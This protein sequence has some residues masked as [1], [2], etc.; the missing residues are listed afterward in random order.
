MATKTTIYVYSHGITVKPGDRQVQSSLLNYCKG[1]AQWEYVKKPPTWRTL[2][3]MSRIFAGA[4]ASRDEFR[5]HRTQLDE[6]ITHLGGSGISRNS[7]NLV[8]VPL[9]DAAIVDLTMHDAH[10]P[11]DNQVDLI[12][13][14]ANPN[15]AIKVTELQTGKG[16]MQPLYSRI[17]VPGGWSTMGEMS[18]G[19]EVIAADGTTAKVT[20]VFPH[21]RKQIYRIT[22][23]DNRHTDAGA[24]HLWKIYYANMLS[25]NKW[26]IVTTI[27][28]L[29]I[30]SIPDSDIYIPL[31]DSEVCEDAE[32]AISAYKVGVCL[33]KQKLTTIPNQYLN[34]STSQRFDV[35][36][37]FLD[38]YRDSQYFNSEDLATASTSVQSIAMDI[39]QL[40]RS[41]GG[42]ASTKYSIDN[43]RYA[44][45]IK[46]KDDFEDLKLKVTRVE[47][48]SHQQ[49]QCIS[50]DHPDHLYVTDDFIVTHNTFC[51]LTASSRMSMR[52]V[53]QVRGGYV[54]RWLDDLNAFFE[55]EHGELLV[56]RGKKALVSI[57]NMAKADELDVKFIIITSKTL[58]SYFKA[59]E[60]NP[61]AAVEEYGCRPEQLYTVL[62]VGT[63][64]VDEV[65]EDYHLNY[66]SDIYCNISNV[67][68]LSATLTTEDAF[69]RQMYDVALPMEHWHK[70][71]DYHAYI[72]VNA[73][74]F[75]MH[76][77]SVVN[78][79]ERG[80]DTYSHGAY[81]L[82][83]LRNKEMLSNYLEMIRMVVQRD[84]IE[85]EFHHGQK[86]IIFCRLVEMCEIVAEHIQECLPDLL[87]GV[88]VSGSEDSILKKSDI[89]VSTPGSAGTAVDIPNL[90]MSLLT[91]A[92]RKKEA[93]EQIKGRLREIKMQ[94]HITPIFNYF[95]NTAIK[96]HREYHDA[97]M[98]QFQ[99]KALSHKVEHMNIKL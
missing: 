86:C 8:D 65:H 71:V 12:D 98:E 82:S 81:E 92:L 39:K 96:K 38:T 34:G 62:H 66:R 73:L 90:K 29:R 79:T 14:L 16:K 72:K 74:H 33:A 31:I 30:L 23:G 18:V 91:I 63:R 2:R 11:R 40:V 35:L 77:K 80:Q 53:I 52:T 4:S 99:G 75:G 13:F 3:V 97:K 67:I 69:R 37:G 70:G 59:Y 21:G 5:F 83:I 19:T 50:I 89:I 36:Q 94:P 25:K 58:H 24:E 9:P 60:A 61:K 57:I 20:G 17:K 48:T 51:A 44:L 47:P 88:Y 27:E 42:I 41:L 64:V 56:V 95:V 93:N 85:Y 7:I 28:L 26:H 45:H 76:D 68:Y 6:V 46:L 54:N 22:F 1:L 78:T 87:V 43:K 15:Q 49:A 10:V 55:F 32:F 84:Y